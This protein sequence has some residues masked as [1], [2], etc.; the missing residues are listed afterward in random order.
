M[1]FFKLAHLGKI[2]LVV[3]LSALGGCETM[4]TAWKAE[5]AAI[6]ETTGE[7]V[8]YPKVSSVETPDIRFGRMAGFGPQER[9]FFVDQVN[10]AA[11]TPGR[12]FPIVAQAVGENNETLVFTYL[13]D[14]SMTPYLSR[15]I[16]ARLTSITRAAPAIAE[17]GLSSE[18][19]VYNM[20]AVLGFARVTVTD[21]RHFAHQADLRQS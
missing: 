14:G 7:G 8:Y 18:F 11:S 13:G 2:A 16:L 6:D 12:T 9:Q 19:D 21:G 5:T 4:P 1:I 10:L 15:G 17:M 20:A 3:S